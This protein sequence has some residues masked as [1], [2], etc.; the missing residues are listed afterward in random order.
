M[1]ENFAFPGP[2]HLFLFACL[3]NWVRTTN[4]KFMI[5]CPLPNTGQSRMNGSNRKCVIVGLRKSTV[6]SATSVI[7]LRCCTVRFVPQ[8]ARP[9]SSSRSNNSLGACSH[10]GACNAP[11][12]LHNLTE[13]L[14]PCEHL[15]LDA[16]GLCSPNRHRL[17]AADPPPH[18]G[19]RVEVAR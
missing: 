9:S 1:V 3:V 10:C 19:S 13:G 8:A 4:A 12:L 5:I 17:L 18:V 15:L 6:P 11:C 2:A 16:R 14:R 7:I